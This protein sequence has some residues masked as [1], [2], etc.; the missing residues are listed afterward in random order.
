[1]LWCVV[2]LLGVRVFGDK[3]YKLVVS[4]YTEVDEH[5]VLFVWST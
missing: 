5:F 3:T 1:M 4:I 2:S